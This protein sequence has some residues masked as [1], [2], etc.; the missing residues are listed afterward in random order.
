M[1]FPNIPKSKIYNGETTP[2]QDAQMKLV[3]NVTLTDSDI[4]VLEESVFF[5]E[6]AYPFLKSID[7]SKITDDEK[8]NTIK[9]LDAV[10]NFHVLIQ[11]NLRFKT[12]FRVSFVRNEFLDS[13]KIRET[14]YLSFPPLEVIKKLGRY[15]RANSPHTT[16]LYCAFNPTIALL[17]TKPEIG[18]RII[19]SQWFKDDNEP[20][21][22]YP[23]ANNETVKNQGL[24]KATKA[25]K[26]R[27]TYNH[28][29]FSRTL[30]LFLEFLSSE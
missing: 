5:Y 22:S 17:E 11:N 10:L 18:D 8:D 1:T 19:I 28:P 9:F 12:L 21:V 27:M 4:K 29:L 16:C 20:F 15:G 2:E 6:Q 23:I 7:L 25:F 26:E 30:E 24:G 3:Q 13:G 14:K